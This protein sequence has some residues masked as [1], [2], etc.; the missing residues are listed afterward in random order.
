MLTVHHLRQSQSDRIIWLCEELGVSYEL[1]SY[2]REPSMA[3]PPDFKSLSPFGTAP[4]ITDGPLVLGESAAIVE[5]ICVRHAG[6]RLIIGPDDPAYADY[7][8]WFHFANGS[9][10]PAMMVDFVT[11][12]AGAPA[13]QG[14]GPSRS[15]RALAMC[16]SRLAKAPYFA[17][18]TFTAAD[19]MM[20]LPWS[21][22]RQNLAGFPN[23]R[24]YVARIAARPAWQR[25]E[26]LH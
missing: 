2:T 18:D 13:L 21:Y 1:K 8:F 16:E 25:T 5:Y 23:V 15:E 17:G 10:V 20:C 19:I 14:S 22:A 4:V 7:L 6:G 11:E 9:L 12:A 3:A 24:G 26:A